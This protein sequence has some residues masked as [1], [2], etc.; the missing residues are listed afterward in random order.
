M[1]PIIPSTMITIKSGVL[2]TATVELRSN[3]IN[4]P[5]PKRP[6]FPL[7]QKTVIPL[8][9]TA[10]TAVVKNVLHNKALRHLEHID[11]IISLGKTELFKSKV[12]VDN[13]E[14]MK[15]MRGGSIIIRESIHCDHMLNRKHALKQTLG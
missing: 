13:Y 9:T 6:H 8:N 3:M 2:Y 14:I 15:K 1:P 12:T 5:C 7:R 4:P 10:T 11:T